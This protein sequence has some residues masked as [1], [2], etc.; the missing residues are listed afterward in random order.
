MTVQEEDGTK[1]KG[2]YSPLSIH[3]K[4]IARSIAVAR[5]LSIRLSY[6]LCW[7]DGDG[8]QGEDSRVRQVRCVC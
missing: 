1:A 5:C 3:G 6:S 2:R 7:K 4:M 8:V